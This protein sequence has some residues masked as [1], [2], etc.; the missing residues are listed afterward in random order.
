MQWETMI[1]VLPRDFALLNVHRI[2]ERGANWRF[3]ENS[4]YVG[5]FTFLAIQYETRWAALLPTASKSRVR[6]FTQKK[7]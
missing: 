7:S 4:T 1:I 5:S 2:L 6:G 3:P